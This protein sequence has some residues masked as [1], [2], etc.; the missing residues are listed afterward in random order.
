MSRLAATS[1]VTKARSF[2]ALIISIRSGWLISPA[3]NLSKSAEST[4][5][6]MGEIFFSS[7]FAM[8]PSRRSLN[9]ASR[10]FFS[11]AFREANLPSGPFLAWRPLLRLSS[12][13]SASCRLSTF[14]TYAYSVCAMYIFLCE[15][16][17]NGDII[18]GDRKARLRVFLLHMC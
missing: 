18:H 8:A 7:S 13:A 12:R 1:A 10:S 17:I 5:P 15:A 16:D 6:R 11:L 3:K 2:C 14:S 9:K 4:N